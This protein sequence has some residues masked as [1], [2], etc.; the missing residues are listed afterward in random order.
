MYNGIYKERCFG[1]N[2]WPWLNILDDIGWGQECFVVF[3]CILHP[4]LVL[5]LDNEGCCCSW[6]CCCCCSWCQCLQ[7]SLRPLRLLLLWYLRIFLY[8]SSSLQ[9]PLA[10]ILEDDVLDLRLVLKDAL[11]RVL[12][13]L[14]LDWETFYFGISKV[15]FVSQTWRQM[16][17]L[18][19]VKNQS[20]ST[21]GHS[22]NTWSWIT[23]LLWM[24]AL[25]SSWT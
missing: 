17:N 19:V 4:S 7:T 24:F 22:D 25:I 2:G 9:T 8:I 11:A 10:L 1:Y 5:I 21:S 16:F 15:S 14:H 13:L 23:L 3:K 20:L 6:C 18:M 12:C